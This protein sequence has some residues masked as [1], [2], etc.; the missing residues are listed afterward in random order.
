MF[1][2]CNW[3]NNYAT[4]AFMTSEITD[5]SIVCSTVCSDEHNGKHQSPALLVLSEGNHRSVTLRLFP[6]RSVIM[7]NWFLSNLSLQWRHTERDGISNHQHREWLIN[8][9]FRRR[10][11]KT[12][13]LRVTGLCV[14]NSPVT[15]EFPAQRA[16]SA[17]YVSIWWRHHGNGTSRN[18]LRFNSL[19][20]S[21]AYM[22]Q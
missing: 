7:E 1:T 11:K 10:S 4:W 21:G 9:L 14:G 6:W 15:G 22:R 5:N 18:G 3:H 8:S 2:R 19:R 13:K 17:E 12:S 16:S 20:P